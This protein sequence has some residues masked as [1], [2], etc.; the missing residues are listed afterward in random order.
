MGFLGLRLLLLV[1]SAPWAPQNHST[2]YS[3]CLVQL[4]QQRANTVQSTAVRCC[5]VW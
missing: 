1:L 2:D 5:V 4:V 3:S